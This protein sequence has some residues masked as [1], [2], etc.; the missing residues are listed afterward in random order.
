MNTDPFL[1]ILSMDT[2]NRSGSQ[3]SARPIATGSCCGVH[4]EVE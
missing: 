4:R 1:A 3:T 2:Y